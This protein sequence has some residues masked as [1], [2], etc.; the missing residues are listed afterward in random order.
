MTNPHDGHLFTKL[1][2]L[3]RQLLQTETWQKQIYEDNYDD[4][5]SGDD[6]DDKEGWDDFILF[7]LV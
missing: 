4:D 7:L 3:T 2:C 6:A 1:I 5:D